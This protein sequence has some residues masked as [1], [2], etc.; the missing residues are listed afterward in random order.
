MTFLHIRLKLSL[1][2]IKKTVLIP[3]GE[4]DILA[5]RRGRKRAIEVKSGS[6]ILSSTD[7][8]K[9]IRKARQVKAKPVLA[10]GP[11]VKLTENARELVKKHNI[12]VKRIKR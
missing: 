7:I 5:Q 2:N 3:A 1:L 11:R 6:Q 12:K 10:I 4:I 9:H 8:R